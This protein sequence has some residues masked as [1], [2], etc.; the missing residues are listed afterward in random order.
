MS[1]GAWPLFHGACKGPP[2]AWILQYE[3][4]PLGML[5]CR[6]E[7]RRRGFASALVNYVMNTALGDTSASASERGKKLFA[8]IVDANLG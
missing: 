3:D 7:F 4:G 8:Y 5:H 6:K 1:N 2:L